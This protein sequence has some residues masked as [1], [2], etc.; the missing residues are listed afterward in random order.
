MTREGIMQKIY[1][2]AVRYGDQYESSSH[3]AFVLADNAREAVEKYITEYAQITDILSINVTE[4][5]ETDIVS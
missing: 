5:Q 1:S 4:R 2:V 3:S